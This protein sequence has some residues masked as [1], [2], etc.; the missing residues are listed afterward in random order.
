LTGFA[1]VHSEPCE[2]TEATIWG[3]TTADTTAFASE[4]SNVQVETDELGRQITTSDYGPG[5]SAVQANP[6]GEYYISWTGGTPTGRGA[7]AVCLLLLAATSGI[8]W[9][10]YAWSALAPRLDLYKLD[11][12]VDEQTPP[13]DLLRR[14]IWP[15]LPISVLDGPRGLYPVL[16]PWLDEGSATGRHIIEGPGFVRASRMSRVR[17]KAEPEVEVAYGYAPERRQARYR[18][19]RSAAHDAYAAHA[20]ATA[21]VGDPVQVEVPTWDEATANMAASDRIRIAGTQPYQLRYQADPHLYGWEGE[22]P[23]EMGAAFLLTDAAMGLDRTPAMV[24]GLERDGADL[25]L[26]V[27][28][29]ADALRD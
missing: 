9:D 5:G 4:T 11:F 23:L 24:G 27:Y 16:W 19:L 10:P 13:L 21:G 26:A 12:Y 22:Q 3:P 17:I 28:I 1:L 18:V 6:D 29:R 20:I 2:V 8:R 7:G 14:K 25:L 15:V